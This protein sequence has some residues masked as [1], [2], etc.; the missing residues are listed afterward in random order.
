MRIIVGSIVGNEKNNYL[1]EWLKNVQSYCDLHVIIDDASN[2]GTKEILKKQLFKTHIKRNEKSQFKE[3]ETQLRND[4]WEE[5]QKH[6]KPDDY[7]LIVDADEFYD[8][9]NE[10]IKSQ[11]KDE[12]CAIRLCDMWNDKEYRTDGN[13]SPYFHRLF[14]FKDKPF[15]SNTLKGLHQSPLPEYAKDNKNVYMTNLRCEHRSYIK[16]KDKKRKHE[17]YM[18]N[19]KG[20][21]NLNHANSIISKKKELAWFGE[22]TY[23]TIL[24]TSL[25]HNR[26]WI[27][28]QFVK[29]LKNIAYPKDKIKYYFVVNNTTDAS[30]KI[31]Q[32][33]FPDA[34]IHEYNFKRNKIG[35]HKWDKTLIY[36][37]AVMRNATLE[38]AEKLKVD[39]MINIDS[40][41]LFPPELI[42]HLVSCDRRIISP[43]F[44]AGWSS[45]NKLPQ[46]WSRGGYD[47]DESL[48]NIFKNYKTLVQVGGLG[49]FT[50]IHKSVWQ[51]G[52]NYTRVENL[53]NDV[54][55]E[56]R[57]FCIRAKVN[58]FNLWAS[59]Y[60][61]LLHVDNKEMLN[62]INLFNKFK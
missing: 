48:L 61:K 32:N 35:E 51:K 60:F 18:K 21:F 11:C 50:C 8:Y 4:L 29:C 44:F 49:A 3:Y 45:N 15:I 33:E 52:V 23:P 17:F 13:W 34:L 56:D 46:C 16:D 25:I 22:K 43:V 42:K 24:I 39:Y 26:D 53:P 27:L 2:D 20:A 37:M 6:A 9:S 10:E 30:F 58:G 14:K 19:S 12:V 55:G 47:L 57:D 1:E 38:I 28:P 41:I 54:F 62:E 59:T 36:H 7:I 40:D 5:I 31:L